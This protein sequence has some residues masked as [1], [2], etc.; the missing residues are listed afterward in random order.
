MQKVERQSWRDTYCSFQL[1]VTLAVLILLSVVSCPMYGQGV[2]G[3]IHGNIG[4]PTHASINRASVAAT[5]QDTGYRA[6]T[7]TNNV[8]EY[9]IP[10]LPP[11]KYDV[12]VTANGFKPLVSKDVAVVVN[13]SATVNFTLQVGVQAEVVSVEAIASLVDTTSSSMGNDLTTRDINSLP[14]NGR[15]YSQLVQVMPGA[16]KTGIGQSAESG[17]GV[18]A[19]GSITAS[20]NGVVYQGTNF[21]LDGV[22]NM[23]QQ[24]AFQNVTPPMDDIQQVKVSGNNAS[25]DVGTYGGAQVKAMIKS[26]TN[27]LHGSA[28]EFYRGRYFN[29]NTWE[30][31]HNNA[32]KPGLLSNQY[33][34]S[35]G[36]AIKT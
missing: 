16:V 34:G 2:T 14:L 6:Q 3:S 17:S 5:N 13:S 11:G 28:F 24:N 27:Q 9:T 25:A 36:G 8:G 4:D 12:E 32:A 29:A 18:G 31:D 33:G 1:G 7:T 23:E 15:V 26:G 10:N 35:L 22:S 30:N 21:T 20:V 19:T